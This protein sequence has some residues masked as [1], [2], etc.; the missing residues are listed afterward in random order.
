[1]MEITRKAKSNSCKQGDALDIEM[2][3]INHEDVI[4]VIFIENDIAFVV[5]VEIA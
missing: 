4:K 2:C 3:Y 1:M 5:E